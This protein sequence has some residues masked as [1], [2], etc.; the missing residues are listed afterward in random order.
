MG[1]TPPVRKARSRRGE[2]RSWA[3]RRLSPACGVLSSWVTLHSHPELV[4][5]LSFHSLPA[6][7]HLV[8]AAREGG[9]TLVQTLP[10]TRAVSKKG[11]S[12]GCP[13]SS[14]HSTGRPEALSALP[15]TSL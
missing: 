10:F 12:L 7:G 8:G 13:S 14:P 11:L 2:G 9:V 1:A 15:S 4:R 6:V 3:Q 5:G